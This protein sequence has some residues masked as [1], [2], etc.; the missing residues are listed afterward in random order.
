MR[1]KAMLPGA[2][3]TSMAFLRAEPRGPGAQPKPIF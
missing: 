1:Q 3:E 2:R